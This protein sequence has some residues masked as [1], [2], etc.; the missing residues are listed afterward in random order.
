M[1]RTITEIMNIVSDPLNSLLGFSSAG[2]VASVMALKRLELKPATPIPS[3][4]E[5]IYFEGKT[6]TNRYKVVKQVPLNIPKRISNEKQDQY[7][8][9]PPMFTRNGI[10]MKIA[11]WTTKHVRSVQVTGS[12]LL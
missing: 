7:A 11:A 2:K 1:T 4:I 12:S 8:T 3:I 9:A 10:A 6:A 5:A